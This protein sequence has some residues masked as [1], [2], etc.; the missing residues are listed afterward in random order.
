MVRVCVCMCVFEEL[1]ALNIFS[2]N[3]RLQKYMEGE[4]Y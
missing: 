4:T 2:P 3:L 1:K